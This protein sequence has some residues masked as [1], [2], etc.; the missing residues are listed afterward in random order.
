M[1]KLVLVT[2]AVGGRQGKIGWHLSEMLLRGGTPVRAFVHTIDKRSE[3]LRALAAEIVQGDF[4]DIGSVRRAVEGTSAIY[5]AYPVQDGLM[6]AT[7]AMALAA[8]QAGVSRLINLVMLRSS[9]D[10]PTPRM[11]QNYLSEQVFE[12]AGIGAVHI[13]ATVF[14]ENLGAM[15]RQS[16][17]AQG[18]IRLPWGSADTVLPLIAGE[19]VARVAAGLLT[20]PQLVAGTAYPL[21]GATISLKEIIAT[22]ARVLGRTCAMKRYRTKSGAATRWRAV[23]TRMR[24]SIYPHGGRRSAARRSTPTTPD[25]LGQ[26]QSNRSAAP[27][28]KLSRLSCAKGTANVPNASRNKIEPRTVVEVRKAAMNSFP[29]SAI[30]SQRRIGEIGQLKAKPTSR[31]RLQFACKRRRSLGVWIAAKSQARLSRPG[32]LRCAEDKQHVMVTFLS[33]LRAK[34]PTKRVRPSVPCNSSRIQSV[35][36]G[37]QTMRKVALTFAMMLSTAT[38]AAAGE[39]PAPADAKVYFINVKDGDTVTS[40]FTIRFGLSGMGVAP[41]GTEMEN[42][43]HHHLIIDE[44]MEGEALNEAI[45]VDEHHMH[46]GKGQTEAAVTL[47]KG[48]HTLQLLLGDWGHVPHKTPVMSDIITVTVE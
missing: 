19:D 2:S 15:V 34:L 3:R 22:F 20:G 10:A 39:T 18:A 42:T 17:P 46:F 30:E 44:K 45:P 4:L 9:P 33:L 6:D 14:Y 27:R 31:D 21:I 32:W 36:Q 25:M 43:G 47:P 26:R 12:W 1:T 7:A 16:L 8:R 48:K 29:V 24:S 5:F 41:A 28:P 13:R 35:I 40:P 37:N 38:L 11:R 23:I